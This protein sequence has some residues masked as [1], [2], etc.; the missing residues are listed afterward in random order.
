MTNGLIAISLPQWQFKKKTELNILVI[1]STFLLTDVHVPQLGSGSVSVVVLLQT[2]NGRRGRYKLSSM[3]RLIQNVKLY[4]CS[5]I[6]YSKWHHCRHVNP[7]LEYFDQVK[8]KR[9]KG[10]CLRQL[11]ATIWLWQRSWSTIQL[12]QCSAECWT[13]VSERKRKLESLVAARLGV[14]RPRWVR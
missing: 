3:Y 7:H 11:F 5:S 1:L 10:Y 12:I 14:S 6:K 2:C 8:K 13:Q 4:W 9:K